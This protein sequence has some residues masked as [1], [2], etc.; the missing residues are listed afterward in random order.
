VVDVLAARVLL[1][2][3]ISQGWRSKDSQVGNSWFKSSG[4]PRPSAIAVAIENLL[5]WSASKSVPQ[6]AL[7]LLEGLASV[8]GYPQ[9]ATLV[10]LPQDRNEV[11]LPQEV[12][13]AMCRWLLD[14]YYDPD[15]TDTPYGQCPLVRNNRTD[16]Y[17]EVDLQRD[18]LRALAVFIGIRGVR[19]WDYGLPRYTTSDGVHV[20]ALRNRWVIVSACDLIT[21]INVCDMTYDFNSKCEVLH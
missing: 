20:G 18:M 19:D 12:A 11:S 15:W 3:L 17:G 10:A 4:D 2:R 16:R 5:A 21:A 8:L 6:D 1:K 14:A 7:H 9:H 13:S